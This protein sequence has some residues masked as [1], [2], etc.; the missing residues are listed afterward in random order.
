MFQGLNISVC[1]KSY[2]FWTVNTIVK[3]ILRILKYLR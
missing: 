3:E 1:K 2:T